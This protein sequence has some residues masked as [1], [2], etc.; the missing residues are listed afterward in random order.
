[1]IFFVYNVFGAFVGLRVLSTLMFDTPISGLA[2][3][4]SAMIT[5]AAAEGVVQLMDIRESYRRDKLLIPT[6]GGVVVTA[7]NTGFVA[8]LSPR[9]YKSE[10][11]IYGYRDWADQ[12]LTWAIVC[13]GIVSISVIVLYAMFIFAGED[14]E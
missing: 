13:I 1:M 7:I 3:L 9:F 2:C 8:L 12:D 14:G 11:R 4:I 5:A 6:L 10:M